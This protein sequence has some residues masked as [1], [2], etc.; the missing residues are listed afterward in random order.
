MAAVNGGT[1]STDRRFFNAP[2]IVRTAY[3]GAAFDAILLGSGDRTNPND[4][5]DPN[6]PNS[7]AVDNQFYMFRDLAINPYFTDA[8]TAGECGADPPDPDFRCRLPLNPADLYDVTANLI[9]SGS[10][11]EQNAAREALAAA[12]GWRLD[13]L[14]NG[15][16]SL[17]RSLTIE[18]KVYFTTFSPASSLVNVC[19]PASGTARLYVVDLLTAVAEEDSDSNGNT[20]RSW[21]IGTLLPDTPAP[22]FG[23]DGEIRLL[24]PPGSGGDGSIGSPYLTG[25]SIPAPYG[26]YWYRE[27]Y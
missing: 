17:S 3:A 23:S 27:E 16:K 1:A 26:S 25:S 22:H 12:N 2:D 5:D 24:L 19:E 9:E 21:I 7:P 10:P 20:D 14:D 15:E 13:L 6:D 4:A 18:G 8:P 11:D